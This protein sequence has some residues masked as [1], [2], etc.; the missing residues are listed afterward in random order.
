MSQYLT[1][2]K[3]YKKE[4][5]LESDFVIELNLMHVEPR[6]EKRAHI[7]GKKELR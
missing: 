1:V 7:K 2:K 5:A 3:K 4:N 6:K